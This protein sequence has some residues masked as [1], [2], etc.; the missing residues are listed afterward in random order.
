MKVWKQPFLWPDKGV[1]NEED[2]SPC[3]E[4]TSIPAGWIVRGF[5]YFVRENHFTVFML[6][7]GLLV[8]FLCYCIL[9][10]ILLFQWQRQRSLIIA[11]ASQ[12]SLMVFLNTCWLVS[13]LEQHSRYSLSM[14]E[15]GIWHIVHSLDSYIPVFLKWTA[16]QSYPVL[17]LKFC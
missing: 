5:H 12:W 8:Y 11:L 10:W 9:W 7:G 6:L 16:R 1:L 3:R 14:V 13:S 17:S 4:S 2:L 15:F